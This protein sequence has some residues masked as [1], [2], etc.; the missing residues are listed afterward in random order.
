MPG[1]CPEDSAEVVAAVFAWPFWLDGASVVRLL[2]PDDDL[3]ARC[4]C[5][6]CSAGWEV[7][8]LQVRRL[9][10]TLVA[11]VSGGTPI[12]GVWSA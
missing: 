7:G 6:S 11:A 9:G 12:W 1:F 10:L 5:L 3:A 2:G 4:A 8:L